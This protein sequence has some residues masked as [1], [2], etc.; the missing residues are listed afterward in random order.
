MNLEL[1]GW[2]SLPL[3]G[4]LFRVYRADRGQVASW[5]RPIL[6]AWSTALGWLSGHSSGK[7]FLDW[8]GY[9]RTQFPVTLMALWLLLVH[10]F[11]ESCLSNDKPT[12]GF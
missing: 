10:A 11:V 2:T 6:W 4:F 12:A 9:A 5:C 3:V 1:Y 8:S 7:L